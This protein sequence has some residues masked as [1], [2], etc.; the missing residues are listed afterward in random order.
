LLTPEK[1]GIL[2]SKMAPGHLLNDDAEQLRAEI[3]NFLPYG[4]DWL[5]TP[6][7]LLGGATPEERIQAGDLEAMRNLF[8]SILYVGVV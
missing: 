8:H 7:Q 1:S 4:Q 2:N 6:S 5:N 3:R